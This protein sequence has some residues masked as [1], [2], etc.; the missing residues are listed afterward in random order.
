MSTDEFLWCIRQ[1]LEFKHL[2]ILLNPLKIKRTH[3]P[4]S[5]TV[6]LETSTTI[7][8]PVAKERAWRVIALFVVPARVTEAFVYICDHTFDQNNELH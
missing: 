6:H 4:C 3:A 2:K 7:E 1:Y 5:L 8:S